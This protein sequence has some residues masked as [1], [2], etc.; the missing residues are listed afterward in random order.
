MPR[1]WI[2]KRF[3]HEF[4]IARRGDLNCPISRCN[5]RHAISPTHASMSAVHTAL[6]IQGIGVTRGQNGAPVRPLSTLTV[7]GNCAKFPQPF[8]L[9]KTPKSWPGVTSDVG[10]PHTRNRHRALPRRAG[11]LYPGPNRFPRHC[12]RN[13]ARSRAIWPNRASNYALEADRQ[14]RCKSLM[15]LRQCTERQ[16]AAADA[17]HPAE[18]DAPRS[19]YSRWRS[20]VDP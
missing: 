13:R 19:S 17:N 5:F 10:N 14:L 7:R 6:G 16:P 15:R 1:A 3:V 2:V 18:Y 9:P 20:L 4:E 8:Q 12:L 11:G